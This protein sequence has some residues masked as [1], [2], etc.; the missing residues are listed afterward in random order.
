RGLH[1]PPQG[2]QADP[3][4]DAAFPDRRS[5]APARA[6]GSLGRTMGAPYERLL[7]RLE[8]TR[9]LGVSLGLLRM[10][11]ALPALRFPPEAPPPPPLPAPPWARPRSPSPPCTSPAP[12][13]RD[14]PPP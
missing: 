8:Q 14:R 5:R 11:Q 9:P 6:G 12:T 13:A 2:S 10:Q 1:R 3:G 7:A 4:Q